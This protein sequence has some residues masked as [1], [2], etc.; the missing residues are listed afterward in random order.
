MIVP[1]AP[2]APRP[3]P[4]RLPVELWAQVLE[5]LPDF[6]SLVFTLQACR[7]FHASYVQF[8]R[9]VIYT[10]FRRACARSRGF[11][12]GHVY[13][14]LA[15]AV[16]YD[17]I[18]RDHVQQMLGIVWGRFR[19]SKIEELLVPIA[20]RLARSYVS[21]GRVPAAATLLTKIWT[22]AEPFG[23]LTSGLFEAPAFPNSLR[24][25]PTY[26]SIGKALMSMVD[27]PER[28]TLSRYVHYLEKSKASLERQVHTVRNFNGEIIYCVG[29]TDENTGTIGTIYH[30]PCHALA[31]PWEFVHPDDA[32]IW[33]YGVI[34]S[35]SP[36]AERKSTIGHEALGCHGI[37]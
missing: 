36:M 2:Q 15:F 21:Q 26:I 27:G 10:I 37:A 32:T 33:G 22:W 14:E 12:I 5:E 19:E 31:M 30:T 3:Y 20:I 8:E 4:H 16:R 1:P 34:Q 29:Q 6:R 24:W 28:E 25:E 7:H 17:V 13:E 35:S 9:R 18:S 23:S 11:Q